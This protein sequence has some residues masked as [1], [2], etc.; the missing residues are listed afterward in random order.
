MIDAYARHQAE[1]H[2]LLDDREGPGDHRLA[3]DDR[4][5]GGE[6]HQRQ[7]QAFAGHQ[8]EGVLNLGRIGQQQRAL[9]RIIDHQRRQD[10]P[11]PGELDRLAPE[12]AHVGI[13]RLGPRHCQHD[14]AQRQERGP[15]VGGEEAHSVQ[16]VQRVEDHRRIVEDVDDAQHRDGEEVEDHDRAE[17]RADLGGAAALNH[18]QADQQQEEPER[19]DAGHEAPVPSSP[20]EEKNITFDFETKCES[21]AV[22]SGNSPPPQLIETETMPERLAA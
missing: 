11:H 1:L 22:S 14:R 10:H 12:M 16:W 20:E 6:Q 21:S 4:R 19:D 9:P 8:E 7:T 13:E 5:H 17:Q 3:G 15:A 18:E 2:R